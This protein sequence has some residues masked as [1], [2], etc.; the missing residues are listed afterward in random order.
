MTFSTVLIDND[1]TGETE[2]I[3]ANDEII[4]QVIEYADM[5]SDIYGQDEVIRAMMVAVT[6]MT[7]EGVD[8]GSMN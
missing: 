8:S 1:E 5:L 4:I 3:S 2:T 7:T 6:A